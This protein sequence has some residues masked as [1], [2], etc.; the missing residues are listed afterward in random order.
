MVNISV[1]GAGTMGHGI[2]LAF[3][4]AGHPAVLHDV[5]PGQVDRAMSVIDLRLMRR[6]EKGRLQEESRRAIM[7]RIA[8]TTRLEEACAQADVVIE[9]I[10][11]RLDLKISLFRDLDRM[12]PDG[13]ILCSNTSQS[14][15]TAMAMATD[16][17]DRVIGTH[18]FVPPDVMRLVEVVRTIYTSDETVAAIVQLCQQAGKDTVVC[19]DSQG[20]ITSRIALAVVLE[21]VRV[22]EEGVAT[23]EDIDKAVELGLNHPMGPLRLADMG[24]LDTILFAADAMRDAAGDRFRAS[25]TFRKL[26]EAGSTG[27]KAGRGFFDYSGDAS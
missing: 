25:Q 22:L 3:A 9:A 17:P 13:A 26:V 19:R 8:P 23:A 5:D 20:F 6:L 18:W 16:R 10:P 2:A 1:I 21:A 7:A 12:A 27:R 14:S 15:V 11:E 24:G 4:Q